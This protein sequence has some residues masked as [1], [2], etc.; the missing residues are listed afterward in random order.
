MASFVSALF[1]ALLP[2]GAAG[3]D[4]TSLLQQSFRVRDRGTAEHLQPSGKFD[5]AAHPSLCKAPFNCQDLTPADEQAWDL[6]G[7]AAN[8]TNWRI[9]CLMPHYDKYS[10]L[11][12]SGDIHGAARAQY[13]ATTAGKFGKYTMEMDG[14]YCFIGGLCAN[15]A[16]T[17][18]TTL[19]EAEE[20]C[21]QR[22]GHEAWTTMNVQ[23]SLSNHTAQNDLKDLRHGF[24]SPLQTRP[25]LL[26]ACAMGNYHCDVRMCQ[27]GYCQD[28]YY[29]KKY[30]HFLQEHGWVE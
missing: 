5:C 8:G 29:V 25:F 19:Q 2:A 26:A 9:W 23:S 3:E 27:V 21:D 17:N 20:M 12:A 14:S 7:W 15:T 22:F 30:G 4:I 18:D 10:S 24:H 28:E 6:H 16:V 11:C 1:L 13:L